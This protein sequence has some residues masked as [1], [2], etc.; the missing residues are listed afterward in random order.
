MAKQAQQQQQQQQQEE[1]QSKME[2]FVTF[3]FFAPDQRCLAEKEQLPH[4]K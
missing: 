3:A 2:I 4:F 1:G